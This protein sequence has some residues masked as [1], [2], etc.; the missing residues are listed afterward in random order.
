MRLIVSFLA[1]AKLVIRRTF[2]GEVM[3]GFALFIS[4]AFSRAFFNPRSIFPF[5]FV[6]CL[7]LV[8]L[9]CLAAFIFFDRVDNVPGVRGFGF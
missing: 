7:L 2:W 3:T 5:I 1:F 6:R 8:L 4:D 9:T